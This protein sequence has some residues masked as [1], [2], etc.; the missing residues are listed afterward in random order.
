MKKLNKLLLLVLAAVVLLSNGRTPSITDSSIVH[1]IGVDKGEN[2]FSVTLQIFRPEAA[3]AD[4]PIDISKANFKTLTAEGEDM[5]QCLHKLS[6][7]AGGELFLGHIQLLVLGED[8]EFDDISQLVSPFRRDKSIYPGLYLACAEN[9]GKIVSFPIKENAVTAENYR[10]IIENAA[11]SGSAFPARLIDMD[12][13]LGVCGTLAMPYLEINGSDEHK[14]LDVTGSRILGRHGFYDAV[15]SPQECS[16]LTLLR[17]THTDIARPHVIETGG[18]LITLSD[19]DS[20]ISFETQNGKIVCRIEITADTDDTI[21]D[22]AA[23]SDP[24]GKKL[25]GS[26]YKYVCSEKADIPRL[27]DTLRLCRPALFL[28]YRD[29]LEELYDDMQFEVRVVIGK[30]RF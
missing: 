7:R 11:S 13:C 12:N 1:A 27:F 30:Q 20:D 19:T 16:L 3:G 14:S 10:V 21:S 2:G 24:V 8:V 28:K 23:L 18:R 5:E 15:I 9:A 4:T 29:R 6:D 25:T 22:S 26:L 17:D